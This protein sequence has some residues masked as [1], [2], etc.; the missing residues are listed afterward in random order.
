MTIVSGFKRCSYVSCKF[1][2]FNYFPLRLPGR[3]F[4]SDRIHSWS[5]LTLHSND[6]IVCAK[7][8]CFYIK[9]FYD[10]RMIFLR[11]QAECFV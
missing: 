6:A 2:F 8:T 1:V 5:L 10:Y 3:D 7:K 4:G 11:S 9:T